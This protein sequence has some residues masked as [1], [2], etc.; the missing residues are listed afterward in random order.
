MMNNLGQ[1]EEAFRILVEG[2]PVMVWSARSDGFIEIL[3]P[4]RFSFHGSTGGRALWLG[5]AEANLS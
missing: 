3:Q 4:P 2:V 5:L 1:S